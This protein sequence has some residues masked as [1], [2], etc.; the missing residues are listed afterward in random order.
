MKASI[1]IKQIFHELH[2]RNK[3]EKEELIN[4]FSMENMSDEE[5]KYPP[6]LVRHAFYFS[7]HNKKE[8][9]LLLNEKISDL[10]N[11]KTILWGKGHHLER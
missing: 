8:I 10:Q 9:D 11:I 7:N 6:C 4:K 5:G 3:I 1:V 2:T